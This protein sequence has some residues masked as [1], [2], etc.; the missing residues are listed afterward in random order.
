[1]SSTIDDYD[2]IGVENSVESAIYDLEFSTKASEHSK[3]KWKKTK[4]QGLNWL[5]EYAPDSYLLQAN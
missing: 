3:Q 1:M 5:K 4:E 2:V